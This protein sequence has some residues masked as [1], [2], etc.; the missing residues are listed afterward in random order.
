ML[1]FSFTKIVFILAVVAGSLL[2]AIPNMLPT[3]VVT[4]LPHWLKPVQLGLDLQGGSHLLLEVDTSAVFKDQLTDL[5]EQARGAL[6]EGKLR[7]RSLRTAEDAVFITVDPADR[8]A[9][10]EAI[11]KSISGMTIENVGDDRIRI[12]I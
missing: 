8:A 11:V 3:S 6:R 5:E 2:F 7:Y 10:R 9:A 1:Q 12:A 4:H